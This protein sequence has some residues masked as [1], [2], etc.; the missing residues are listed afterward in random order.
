[1]SFVLATTTFSN[2]DDAESMA[3]LLVERKLAACVQIV[4]PVTSVYRW[5]DAI[6][7]DQELL[8][9]IKTRDDLIEQIGDLFSERH[10][11]DVPELISLE[12]TDGSSG[13]LSWMNNSLR[14]RIRGS[15]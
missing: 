5:Q 7:R 1:V 12:I 6:E 10:P 13:Y 4:A 14:E 3:T 15:D 11:Y 9:L 2:R 8:L